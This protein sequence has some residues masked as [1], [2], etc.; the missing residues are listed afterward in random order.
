MAGM[1]NS[2][3]GC[4][5]FGGSI[6]YANDIQIYDMVTVTRIT[7]WYT[8]FNLDTASTVEAYL[9]IAPKTGAIPVDGTDLPQENGTLVPVTMTDNGMGAYECVADGLSI[10]LTPG[11]YWVSLTPI[12]PG[13]A[14]GPDFAIRALDTVG[15]P[16]AWYEYCG[17][18]APAWGTN[19]DGWD[20][21][22]LIEG[23]IDA[24]PNEDTSL[25]QL[26]GR[27]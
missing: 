11:E 18:F 20:P 7:T 17:Q 10:M 8:A 13:G 23:N 5:P 21:A 22:I 19:V 16:G 4:A 15:E 24:V 3:S 6:H 2:V 9:Y 1:W 14:W 27:F 12:M 26:K 25:G